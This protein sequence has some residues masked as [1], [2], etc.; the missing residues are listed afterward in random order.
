MI[1]HWGNSKIAH[2]SAFICLILLL[3][4]LLFTP[5]ISFLLT[6][7]PKTQKAM[8]QSSVMKPTV[9]CF[10][11]SLT[12][13]FPFDS[14]YALALSK[15]LGVPFLGKGPPSVCNEGCCVVS[16]LSGY[17]AS[18][19]VQLA[20]QTNIASKRF[21]NENAGGIR[22]MLRN[23]H[24]TVVIVMAGTND[25]ADTDSIQEIL[26]SLRSLHKIVLDTPRTLLV[27]LPV[28]EAAYMKRFIAKNEQRLAINKALQKDAEKS[29]GRMYFIDINSVFPH[30]MNGG[31]WHYDG[32][33]MTLE[34]YESLGTYVG[35][36]LV[37]FLAPINQDGN[38]GKVDH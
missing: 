30:D 31:M 10:G 11:D 23:H 29:E 32:L 34:G 15:V 6:A 13:G 8:S 5:Q 28:P 17:R 22:A 14:P 12:A 37:G 9:L 3:L 19:F 21:R 36:Q 1:T 16:A 35:Q 27:A 33:H 25:L 7:S 38:N 18:E 20:N 2:S 4:Y 26:D 24:F